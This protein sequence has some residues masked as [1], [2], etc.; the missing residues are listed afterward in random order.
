[1][2]EH[3]MAKI[4]LMG[5][6]SI[7]FSTTLMND[8]L[9]VKSLEG[10]TY[11]LMGPTLSKLQKVEEYTNKLIKKNN[12]KATVYSTTDRRDALKDSD[13][14]VAMLQIGGMEASASDNV[15]APAAFSGGC[16]LF[17]LWPISCTTWRSS[18]PTR[19]S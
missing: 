15:S 13:Y 8:L 19:C 14:V 7:I 11:A 9:Q 1:M 2:E 5:A 6:G 3:G 10:S 16:A 18:A 12:L 4:A 17:L